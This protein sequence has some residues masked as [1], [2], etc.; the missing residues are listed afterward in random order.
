MKVLNKDLEKN[1]KK[2][3]KYLTRKKKRSQDLTHL[4]AEEV[5]V[6]VNLLNAIDRI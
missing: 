1:N 2:I 3:E 5:I 4:V 6:H